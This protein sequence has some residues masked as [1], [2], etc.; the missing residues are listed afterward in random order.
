MSIVKVEAAQGSNPTSFDAKVFEVM[1]QVN[2]LQDQG[3]N[4]LPENV[5]TTVMFKQNW[6]QLI[7][8]KS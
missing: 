4:G 2:R 6:T 7:L 3:D 8:M 1:K 5:Y